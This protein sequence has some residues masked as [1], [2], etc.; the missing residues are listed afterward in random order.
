LKLQEIQH[1]FYQEL[2]SIYPKT[3]IKTF[4]NWLA[5]AYLQWDTTQVLMRADQ[6]ISTEKAAQ[7]QDA[8]K[9]LKTEKP[10]QYIL[11]ETEFY[12]LCFKVNPSVL[13]PRP[14]TEE[15]VDWIITDYKK[16]NQTTH[17]TEIGTGSGCIS[18][19]LAKSNPKLKLTAI[20]VSDE[21]LAV[22][23]HNANLHQVTVRFMQQDILEV[24]QLSNPVDVI[25]SNP[26]YVKQDERQLM[27]DNV[28]KYEPHLAL[29]VANNSA[30]LFYE[31]IIQLGLA[32]ENVPV[33]YVEINAGLAKETKALFTKAGFNE[34]ILKKDI[35]GKARIIKAIF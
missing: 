33:I 13:I 24:Q 2:A 9:E 3:E 20:D 14:E 28:L 15:L 1:Q 25:V 31:K 4:F 22:A 19:S 6:E 32:Q 12:G 11:G 21:A 26:P 17:I 34:V 18:V 29:F 5:E 35:F 27:K 16:V 23:H 10:I 30:L 7:F 8:L